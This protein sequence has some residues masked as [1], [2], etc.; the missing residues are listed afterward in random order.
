[1]GYANLQKCVKD[2]KKNK[3]LIVIDEPVDPYLE[4]GAIARRVYQHKGPA[5]L[6][7]Q[8]KDTPF[9]M[10]ANLFGTID[11]AR[12]LFR[13]TLEDVSRFVRLKIDPSELVKHPFYFRKMPQVGLHMWPR[14]VKSGPVL[15]HETSISKLPQLHSWPE[16]GGAFITLPQVYTE[17]I[18][19]SGVH[20]SNLGMYR[21]QISGNDYVENEEIGLHYQLHRSIGV[22]HQE[23]VDA[24]KPFHVNIFVGGPPA[25]TLAA[26]MPLPEGLP[27]LYFAGALGGRRIKMIHGASPLPILAEADFCITGTVIPNVLKPEGPFGD[28]LGY[29]SLQHDFPVLKVEKVYHRPNAIWPFTTVGRPPQEDTTFGELIHEMTGPVIPTVLPGVEQIHAVDAA[30]VHPLLLAMGSERYTP[31]TQRTRPTEI[32]TQANAILGQGQLSLA[33]YLLIGCQQDAPELKIDHVQEFLKH[34]LERID[35]RRD[36][37]FQTK[38]TMDTLDYSGEEL[39]YGSKLVLAAVGPKQR[40]LQTTL[41]QELVLPEGF[42]KPHVC[43]PGVMA[44]QAPAYGLEY[45]RGKKDLERFCLFYGDKNPINVFPL[46]ILVDDSEF[47][48]RTLSNF[49]WVTFTRSN[50]ALDVSGIGAFNENKHWGCTGSL[51]IDAR[52]KPHHAPP[53]EDDSVIE[54]RVNQLGLAGKPLH[55]II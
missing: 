32:L 24:G 20:G 30:G 18:K 7:T 50:P 6:F 2:L 42:R 5:L 54:E 28:H 41:P 26:V 15:K 27:E 36:C 22:H 19:K 39:N 3:D 34:I 17:S 9:P 25:M 38:T 37:H 35:F 1:M 31:Y 29:Y 55:G 53:L 13:D 49:I 16:D 44:L 43:M 8:V 51:V 47:V 33:K 52:I 40:N 14:K 46:I 48:S 4:V 45:D 21:I 12:F 11:R 10:L 23:A